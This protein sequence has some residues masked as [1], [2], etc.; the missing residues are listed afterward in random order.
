MPL[1]NQTVSAR[2]VQ[3][4]YRDVVK[5]V[6]KSDKPVV[7]MN[8]NKAQFALMSLEILEEYKRLKLFAVIN[9][10]Q[11]RNKGKS[12]EE[13]YDEITSEVEK[14]RRKNYEEKKTASFD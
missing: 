10:I 6:E 14:T 4:Q 1:L 12:I 7:V 3:R 9:D 5:I 11:S 8:R 13:S 2:D